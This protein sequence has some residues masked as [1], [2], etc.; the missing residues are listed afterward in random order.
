MKHERIVMKKTILVLFIII[1]T[2]KAQMQ[3]GVNY[4][5]HISFF[6]HAVNCAHNPNSNEADSLSIF[7]AYTGE[8]CYLNSLKQL[9]IT[10]FVT[11]A[12]FHEQHLSSYRDKFFLNDMGF[13]W[14]HDPT[15]YFPRTFLPA[16]YMNSL[17]HWTEKFV[18]QLG[19]SYR[20]TI[21]ADDNYGFG[22]LGSSN[23]EASYW[24][25]RPFLGQPT[26]QITGTNMLDET[27]ELN[28]YSRA[29]LRGTHQAGYPL[30]WAQLPWTQFP[31]KCGLKIRV[32]FRRGITNGSPLLFTLRAKSNLAEFS[33]AHTF[34]PKR[35]FFHS[36]LEP[37]A[38]SGEYVFDIDTTMLGTRHL[39]RYDSLDIGVINIEANNNFYFQI[40]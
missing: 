6:D 11:D 17:G 9:G 24:V 14:K 32:Y 3:P 26:T 37:D 1:S 35:D 27:F 16:R 30:V 15:A 13:A 12:H 29:A 10:N 39:T 21:S 7:N 36:E 19:G 4:M 2:I 5:P 25:L 33:G 18:I 38:S 22:G 23:T 8:G 34:A 40:D 28:T 31:T 20:S